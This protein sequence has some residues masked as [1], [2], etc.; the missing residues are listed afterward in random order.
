MTQAT[1]EASA[2]PAPGTLTRVTQVA[3]WVNGAMTGLASTLFL[4]GVVPHANESPALAH[5]VAAGHYFGVVLLP[6]VA[7]R[8]RKDPSMI[9]LAI[10]FVF[11][12]WACSL[13]ELVATRSPDALPPL[14]FESIFLTVYTVFALARLRPPR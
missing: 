10:A 6:F 2:R 13:Y 4:A 12:N 7:L 8:L 11:L 14:T 9:L 1:I 5:R 3:L